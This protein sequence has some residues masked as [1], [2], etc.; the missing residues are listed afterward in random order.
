[1]RS[2]K[3]VAERSRRSEIDEMRREIWNR[4]R[5]SRTRQRE[6]ANPHDVS[7]AWPSRKN[8]GGEF[9]YRR[10][11]LHKQLSDDYNRDHD[12]NK[13]FQRIRRRRRKG[14]RNFW[15]RLSLKKIVLG[16]WSTEYKM[17]LYRRYN[18]SSTKSHWYGTRMSFFNFIIFLFVNVISRVS[19]AVDKSHSVGEKTTRW[20]LTNCESQYPKRNM[21]NIQILP[22][23]VGMFLEP[24]ITNLFLHKK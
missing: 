2:K 3:K 1:M 17:S 14:S 19:R 22:Y 20:L 18:I 12:F 21:S 10:R 5:S 7:V 23:I 13:I 15:S 11:V 6:T 24:S 16:I 4:R 8:T 9:S